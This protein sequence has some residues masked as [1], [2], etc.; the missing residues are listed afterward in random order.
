MNNTRIFLSLSSLILCVHISIIQSLEGN[1]KII[2]SSAPP[3]FTKK[4]SSVPKVIFLVEDHKDN[5]R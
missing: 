3:Q 4:K 5:K 1:L 2:E